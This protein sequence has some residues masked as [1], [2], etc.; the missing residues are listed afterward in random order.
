MLLHT[1][2]DVAVT[3]MALL[4]VFVVVLALVGIAGSDR[5]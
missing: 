4:I 2:G 3:L 1:T 5:R